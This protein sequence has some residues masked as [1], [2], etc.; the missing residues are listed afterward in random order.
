[1]PIINQ[2]SNAQPRPNEQHNLDP[3]FLCDVASPAASGNLLWQGLKIT[4]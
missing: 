1:M 2:Y 3:K 4:L